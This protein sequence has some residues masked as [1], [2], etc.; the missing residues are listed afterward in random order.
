MLK[1]FSNSKPFEIHI[2]TQKKAGTKFQN[3]K[4]RNI[5]EKGLFGP[6]FYQEPGPK[7]PWTRVLDL[8]LTAHF[9]VPVAGK[10]R[11]QRG[12]GPGS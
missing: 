8:A 12:N 4:V 7:S 3:W 6:G 1:V 2:Q 9:L 5:F 11:D 10:N